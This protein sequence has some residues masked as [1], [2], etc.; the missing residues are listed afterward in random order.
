[1]TCSYGI[2]SISKL[3]NNDGVYIFPQYSSLDQRPS[4]ILVAATFYWGVIP[5]TANFKAMGIP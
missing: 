2:N 4:L 3:R 1:M 5:N